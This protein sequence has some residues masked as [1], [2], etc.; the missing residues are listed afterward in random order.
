MCAFLL[1]QLYAKSVLLAVVRHNSV[2]MNEIQ[3][4]FYQFCFFIY[5][6]LMCATFQKTPQPKRVRCGDIAG[7]KVC[8]MYFLH[9]SK[10]LLA[11]TYF[12]VRRSLF[13]LRRCCKHTELSQMR[14]YWSLWFASKT[15][16]FPM[17][18]YSINSCCISFWVHTLRK[19]QR[20]GSVGVHSEV[21]D[22]SDIWWSVSNWC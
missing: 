2:R 17:S 3:Q 9:G 6:I 5:T 14:Y 11:I 12:M 7:G 16:T 19:L 18:Q 4:M 22:T 20:T 21:K 10:G 1:G 15:A 8:K 13:P